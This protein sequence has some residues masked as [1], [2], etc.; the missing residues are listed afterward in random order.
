MGLFDFLFGRKPEH[1][2]QSAPHGRL[3][4][5]EGPIRL[6]GHAAR[7]ENEIALERY[8][9]M[10]RTA[11]PETIEQAH[12]EA[13]AR[14]TPEQRAYV[15]QALASELPESER[16]STAG[17]DADPQRMA[18]IAT[19]AEMR[20][21]GVMERTLANHPAQAQQQVGGGMLSGMAGTLLMSFAA[22]FVGSMAA[23]AFLSSMGDPFAAE[24]DALEEQPVFE[25]EFSGG[26]AD[27]DGGFDDVD[28]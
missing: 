8:R 12:A 2:H 11:P 24:M 27:F 15:L 22:G 19:R 18:R 7:D 26:I 9:Y 17:A 28:L 13:F 5:G 3:S 16:L 10:L 23:N 25:E 14:L 21:P 4:F 20:T 6:G 1:P